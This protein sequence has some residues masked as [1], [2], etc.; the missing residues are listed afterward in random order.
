MN[1][2]CADP[3]ISVR[4]GSE[5][6]FSHQSNKRTV[7]TTIEKQLDPMGPIAS[8]WG[9]FSIFKETYKQLVILQGRGVRTPCPPPLDLPM[10]Q[11]TRLEI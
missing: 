3:E 11:Q 8:R 4:G 6:F 5:N 9:P 10:L 2:K 1:Y 7:R